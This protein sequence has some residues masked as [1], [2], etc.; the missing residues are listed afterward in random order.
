M[1]GSLALPGNQGGPY[2][3]G[4]IS[5]SP[6]YGA[7]PPGMYGASSS[8][9]PGGAPAGGGASWMGS[10]TPTSYQGAGGTPATPAS[11]YSAPPLNIQTQQNP[12]LQALQGDYSKLRAGLAAGSDQDATNTLQR[13]RDLTSGMAQEAG[14]NAQFRMGPG[15]G[16]QRE[17][18]KGVYAQGA[19]NLSGLNANLASDARNK[20]LNALNSQTGAAQGA[21][22]VD[23]AQQN[24]ALN[25]WQAQQSASQAQAQLA[26]LQQQNGFQ[27]QLSL[28]NLVGNFYSGY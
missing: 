10:S 3:N 16:A 25:Q 27:N 7:P 2:G 19:A 1:P 17:A 8:N 23:Q 5:S 12:Q 21:A 20:Q 24:F 6:S 26:A 11:S 9:G 13:Q 14:Q 15:S 28:A 4:P 18:T 22:Q